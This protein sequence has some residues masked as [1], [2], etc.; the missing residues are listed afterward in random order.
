V[1]D[2]RLGRVDGTYTIFSLACIET[3]C[4]AFLDAAT[5]QDPA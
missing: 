4:R 1:E 2:D 5:A 3:W